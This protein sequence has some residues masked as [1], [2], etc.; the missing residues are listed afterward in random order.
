MPLA[1]A[2]MLKRYRSAHHADEDPMSLLGAEA[3]S[4]LDDG[5]PHLPPPPAFDPSG[6]VLAA[7]AILCAAVLVA[8]A[9]GW[10]G[11]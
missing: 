9:F 10:T 6:L 8:W 11:F 5:R 4:F 7:L 3:S 1:I 2:R